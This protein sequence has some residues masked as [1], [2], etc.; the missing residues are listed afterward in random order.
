MNGSKKVEIDNKVE[1]IKSIITSLGKEG[2]KKVDFPIRKEEY[3]AEYYRE[4]KNGN[5][6]TKSFA[7]H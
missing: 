5:K 4:I 3:S 2:I 6:E 7:T 1:V